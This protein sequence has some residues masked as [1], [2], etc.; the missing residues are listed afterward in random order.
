MRGRK[1]RLDADHFEQAER[2][3]G[4][5]K[6]RQGQDNG[7]HRLAW[8]TT[9]VPAGHAKAALSKIEGMHNAYGMETLADSSSECSAGVRVKE[10]GILI[11]GAKANGK[12]NARG[13]R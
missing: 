2:A 5:V 3:G 6:A 11:C 10:A 12:H 8:F 4:T 13:A 1:C 7:E 9:A